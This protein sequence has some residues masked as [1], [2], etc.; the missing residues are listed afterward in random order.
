MSRSMNQKI[1]AQMFPVHDPVTRDQL[2]RGWIKVLTKL[3]PIDGI[4][5]YFGSK[6]GLYFA[7]LQ[8]YTWALAIHVL[9][10]ILFWMFQGRNQS[11]LKGASS[12]DDMN[13][14]SFA[15]FNVIWATLYLKSWKRR[16]FELTYKWKTFSSQKELASEPRPLFKGEEKISDITGQVEMFYPPWKTKVFRYFVSVPVIS[17]CLFVCFATVV[18]S[19]RLQDWWDEE[20]GVWCFIP[21]VFLATSIPILNFVYEKIAPFLNDMENHRTEETHQNNLIVKLILF[22]FMNSFLSLFYVAFYLQDMETLTSLLTTILITRQFIGTAKESFL[23]YA[24]Q[25]FNL[26]SM[27]LK[28]SS[29]LN[30]THIKAEFSQIE[31]ESSSPNYKGTYEEYMEIFVQFGYVTFF[32]SV[33]PLAGFLALLNNIFEIRGDALK[34]CVAYQRPFGERV[35]NIGVWQ[36]AMESMGV[37]AIIVNCALI[38]Q[39]GQI[40][41]FFPDMSKASMILLVVGLEHGMLLTKV[42]INRAIPDMPTWVERELM[43]LEYRRNELDRTNIM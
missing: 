37:I 10:G 20:I 39:S 11:I 23:P 1:I 21:K 32:S 40:Y 18:I 36:G 41:N 35:A 38:C 22:Q 16:S 12:Y 15:F 33:Y 3:P 31:R 17:I 14:I 7:W 30:P 42:L 26:L 9:V 13:S 6:I 4:F 34:L 2:Q 25:H 8:H 43:R 28:D 19:L 27:A 5:N 24:I 29:T